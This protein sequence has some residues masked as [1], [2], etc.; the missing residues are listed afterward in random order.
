MPRL[1]DPPPKTRRAPTAVP[2]R[3][4]RTAGTRAGRTPAGPGRAV[5]AGVTW[6]MYVALRDLPENDRVKMTYDGPA[7][8]LL[9]IEMPQG[10]RHESVGTLLA[11]LISAFAEERRIPMRSTGSVTLRREDAGRGC[12]GDA[13]F[14]VSRF[15]AVRG[16]DDNLLDL[17]VLPPPDLG[18]EVDVTSPGVAKLPIY[19]ALGVPEVWVWEAETLTVHRLTDAGVF[20]AVGGSGELVGFPLALAADLI[21]RRA[22]APQFELLAEFREA[23]REVPSPESGG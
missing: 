2:P 8:G 6:D 14:Y 16:I 19:A 10:L 13:S 5:L 18:V 11:L 21:A 4:R 23:V 7:G 1:A 12:D 20:E 15:E 9:E 3:P 17:T 22:D